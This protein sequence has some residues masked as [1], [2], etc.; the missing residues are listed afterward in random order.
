MDI[1]SFRKYYDEYYDPLCRFLSFYTK[2]TGTIEDVIQEVF[3]KLWE[4]KEEADIRYVKTYLFHA[5]KNKILNHLREEENRHYLLDNWFKQ[6]KWEKQSHDCFDIERFTAL[7]NQT[8][9]QL[10]QK[11]KEIFKLSREEK[12]SYKEIAHKLDVSVKTVETQ[13]SIA[14]KKIREAMLRASFSFFLY[15][16]LHFHL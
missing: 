3:I 4:S 5:A 11:C 6:Q 7:L 1:A 2:D 10:P 16:C 15:F 8:I 9:E 12:L 14:L 13:I